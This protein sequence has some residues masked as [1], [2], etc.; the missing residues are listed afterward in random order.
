MLAATFAEKGVVRLA[1]F[2]VPEAAPGE[3]LLRVLRCGICGS[4]LHAYRGAWGGNSHPGHELCA[5][6]EKLGPGVS[7]LRPGARVTAECFAHCGRCEACRRG[8]YNLCE[9]I[10]FSP[11]RPAG[12]MAEFIAYPAAGLFAVPDALS[13]EQAALVEPLAVAFRAVARAGVAEGESVAVVGGGTIG[14]LCASVAAARGAGPVFLLAKYPHQV[15][16]ARELGG[17]EPLLP[18]DGN[19]VELIKERAGRVDVALDCAAA[20][21]SFT[22]ALSLVRPQ[23]RVVEV[24]GVTRPL[25]SALSPLVNGE[26]RVTGSSCYAT[27]DGRPDFEWAIQL[28]AEGKLRPEALVTHTFPL[29]EAAEAF[30]TAADKKSGSVKVLLRMEG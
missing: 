17:V 6:V 24:G 10:R 7:A 29:A 8:D 2:D 22:T 4:D 1:E 16:K 19:P 30:R 21:T 26:L 18:Q 20:G 9:A 27:T 11:G 3:V 25:L 12:G 13:D 14:L 23:G 15:D 28:I 5:V